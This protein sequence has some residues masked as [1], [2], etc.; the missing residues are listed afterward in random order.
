MLPKPMTDAEAN[1]S[2]DR[3]K[4]ES[5]EMEYM[6]EESVSTNIVQISCCECGLLID[7]NPS[8]TCVNCLKSRIDITEGIQKQVVLYFCRGCERYMHSQ[9][10]WIYCALESRELLSLCL[11]KLKGLVKVHLVDASF[12][13]TE[14]HSKRLKVKLKIQK[15]VFGGAILQQSFVVEYVVNNFTCDACHRREAKDFWRALV[16][17]RQKAEHK[18]TFFYL[19]QLILKHKAAEKCVSIK[20]VHEGVDFF[21]DK[22]DDARKL[23]DFLQTVVPCR[24]NPSKELVSHDIHNNTYNYKHTFAVE[25]L[26]ICKDDIV[27]LPQSL[28]TSLANIGPLCICLRVTN[29]VYLIDPYTLK[30]AELSGQAY[31]RHPFR[32]MANCKQLTEFIVMNI[33]LA[34][35]SETPHVYPRSE[36]HV[37]ADV[38]LVKSSELGVNDKQIHTRTHLGHI[39]NVGDTVLALDL[40]T[41]NINEFNFEKYET[42]SKSRIPDVIIVKKFYGDKTVR[43]RK[44]LWKLRRLDIENASQG[45]SANRDFIDFMEDLE[46]DYI[47][48]QHINIFKDK[49]RERKESAASVDV[50]E[51]DPDAPEIS[52]EEMLEDLT[53]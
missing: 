43:N 10:Q 11:K 52:L 51:V 41:A 4:L 13:W 12:V 47:S 6:S 22:K 16:Q 14:P 23:V 29:Y 49:E 27:C 31:W 15:E 44:R 32:S 36:K 24:Y 38:W 28:S 26:P 8:N 48:R 25:I 35:E 7:P 33:E 42:S 34:G 37:L 30:V 19:E 9:G 45:S 46:E 20:A 18:K 2:N 21:F 3:R 5:G 1:H 53:V 17:V 50:D 40:A 39:L